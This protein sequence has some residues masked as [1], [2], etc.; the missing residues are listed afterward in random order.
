MG[1]SVECNMEGTRTTGKVCG[2][3]GADIFLLLS[4]HFLFVVLINA[5]ESVS[6]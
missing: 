2:G 4:F 5:G 1:S 3:G 6:V